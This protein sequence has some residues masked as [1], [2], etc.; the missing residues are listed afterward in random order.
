M[1]F[2]LV[3]DSCS[4]A[5]TVTQN[6]CSA[7]GATLAWGRVVIPALAEPVTPIG[8]NAP[9]RT[10]IS[11]DRANTVLVPPTAE[12]TREPSAPAVAATAAAAASPN[13]D[14]AFAKC[15]SCAANVPESHAFCFECGAPMGQP[16]GSDGT[17]A[18]ARNPFMQPS[19]ANPAPATRGS[20]LPIAP[21]S[22]PSLDAPAGKA[23]SKTMFFGAMQTARAKLTVIRG[24]GHDGV[25][26]SLA[27]QEHTFGRGADCALLFAE[28]AYLS[29][30]H[31][32]FFYDSAH[33]GA[34]VVR[35]EGSQ[36][37]VFVRIRGTVPIEQG[38]RFLAGEQLFE[39]A[40]G[41][42][43]DLEFIADGTYYFA[44]PAPAST[45]RVVQRLRGGSTA[46]AYAVSGGSFTIG[47]EGNDANF[48]NDPFISG[49]HAQIV[50]TRGLELTDLNSKNGTFVQIRGQ[51]VLG[52]G[53]YVFLGQQ[54]LR[55]EIV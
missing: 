15:S 19:A 55:I 6:A 29:P 22:G 28:D 41:H 32:N 48:P 43:G 9:I 49:R 17:Q 7:C 53:D 14:E 46:A 38:S 3:C 51:H 52:H 20:N 23:A 42:T 25:S 47:R 18:R 5:N 30:I 2:A 36:N 11:N 21:T 44:S 34:L 35:D 10:F 26:Y 13:S 33:G 27:G 45:L 40:P 12:P 1:D 31:A 8:E 4:A 16:L 50:T 24:D 37:G 39:I 54:L